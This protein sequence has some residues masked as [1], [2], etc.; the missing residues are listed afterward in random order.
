MSDFL[1]SVKADLL[2][3]R[4][5]LAL[6][7]LAIG[8]GGRAWPTPCSRR[9]GSNT[10]VPRPVAPVSTG[11]HGIAISQAPANPAEPVAETTSG[12]AHQRGGLARDPFTPLVAAKV[13]TTPAKTATSSSS[14]TSTADELLLAGSGATTPPE[15][16]QADK[17]EDARGRLPRGRAVRCGRAPERRLRTVQLTP[18]ENLARLTPLPSSKQPLV[19]FR[20]VT[21]GGKSATFTLAGEVILHGNAACVPSASQC[22][23]IELQ[24]GQTEEARIL[25]ARAGRPSPT[26]W[27]W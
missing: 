1:N 14:S 15:T 3:V 24:P 11:V 12:A 17:A 22:Q 20:G 25:P 13:A 19:V 7:V 21:V 27:R 23:A 5:R 2:D 16:V 9:V 6:V 10:A 18:Y 26:S 8:A 4:L